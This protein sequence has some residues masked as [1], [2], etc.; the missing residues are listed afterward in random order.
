MSDQNYTP[1]VL[2][3]R[4]GQPHGHYVTTTRSDGGIRLPETTI[5]LVSLAILTNGPSIA[6]SHLYNV[7]NA[8]W[9]Q[10]PFLV[11]M[12]AVALA[13]VFLCGRDLKREQIQRARW[14][15]ALV[16]AYV[17]WIVASVTWSVT[18]D[19]TS[20]RSLV[21]AGV[22][23]MGIWY[24]LCLRFR[25]QV[26]ALF[27]SMSL[28]SVWSLGLIL[29]QPRTHQ[30]YP[31]PSHPD[32]HTQVFGVFGNPNSLG[33][34]A[35]LSVLS[36]IAVWILFPSRAARIATSI[37]A[38]IGLILTFWS[39][40]ETA[41][42][43]LILGSVAIAAA[44]G[45]RALRRVSGWI[46]GGSMVVSALVLWRLFFD[47]LDRIAPLIGAD[48]MLSSR[49]LIWI[50]MRRAIALRPWR[51]YGFFAFWDNP[52][53]TA[54]TYSNIGSGYGSAHNSV[55]EVALGLGRIG[56]VI[57]VSMAVLMVVGIARSVWRRTDLARLA[58]V[59]MGIFLIVQNA[60]ESFVLWHSYLWALFV[61]A[62]VI[63]SRLLSVG[64][65]DDD[66]HPAAAMINDAT[67]E[68]RSGAVAAQQL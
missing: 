42:A 50:D 23:A 35:A 64:Q 28:L 32:W 16:M 40:C 60:L 25:E 14:P 67:D 48:A 5:A 45:L 54:S 58:W 6:I 15:L 4:I 47:H 53:F 49:R 55:L 18:P 65:P 2:A 8:S 34:V 17:V 44:P 38:A 36:S 57:Y 21:T 26:L 61:A 11:P 13:G 20:I 10:W 43:A 59:V 1:A 52:A 9:E 39:Q 24:A 66:G 68:P 12:G 41:V 31:P 33:P 27:L 30:I 29:L 46:V 62:V 51:G 7:V 63:P 22:S 19:A 56:L 3:E 37:T